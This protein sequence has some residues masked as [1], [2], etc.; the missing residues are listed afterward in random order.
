L[1]A[2]PYYAIQKKIVCASSVIDG[3][4]VKY[5]L[6]FFPFPFRFWVVVVV[7]YQGR[8]MDTYCT[9]KIKGGRGRER[10]EEKDEWT[11]DL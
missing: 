2:A 3:L 1:Q 11:W 9:R 5:N 10:S 8:E 4:E 7:E 6:F